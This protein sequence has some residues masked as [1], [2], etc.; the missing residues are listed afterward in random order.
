MLTKP[1]DSIGF[2][3]QYDPELANMMQKELHRQQDGLELIASENFTSPAVM[4]AMGSLLPPKYAAG[5]PG[6]R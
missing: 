6:Q 4:A 2:V 1:M 5:L 3:E